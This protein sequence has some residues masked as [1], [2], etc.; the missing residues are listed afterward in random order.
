MSQS[1]DGTT[2]RNESDSNADTCCLG[3]N[4]VILSMTHRTADVYPYDSSYAPMVNVPIVSGAT[5]YDCSITNQTYILVFNEALFYGSK[6][7]HSLI[8]PNQLRSY[9][10][11]FWDNPYDENH[12]LSIDTPCGLFMPLMSKGTKIYFNSRVP[13]RYELENCAHIDMTSKTEWNP[14]SMTLGE[15]RT[16]M[17]E[18]LEYQMQTI[19]TY[20]NPYST[21]HKYHR[22]YMDPTSD[23]AILNNINPSLVQLKELMLSKINVQDS[24]LTDIPARRTFISNKRHLKLSAESIS[25]LWGIGIKRA[26]ATLRAT[27]QRGTRSAI[28][29]LSRRYR[30]D[31][32]YT[33]KR[34]NGKFSTD[35][36][37]A[38]VSSLHHNK[39]A[40]LYSHQ[41]GF[42]VC[43]PM[44]DMSGSTIGHTLKC[45]CHDFGVPELLRS[46]GHQSM[47]G[48]NTLFQELVRLHNIKHTVSE[49]YR[50]SQNPAEPS[51]RDVKM[52]WY[53]IMFKKN[54]PKRVWDYGLIWICETGNISVSSSK[55]AK[56]RTPI[57]TITG[58]TPDITEYTDFSFYDWIVFKPNAGLGTPQ[59]GRW[60]GVSHR[61]GDL[62]SYFVLPISCQ[63]I[64]CVTVQRLTHA[65]QQTEV[66]KEYM[67][68]YNETVST[69]LHPKQELHNDLITDAPKW[70]RLSLED[71]DNDFI[72]SFNRIIDD[73][74]IPHI[75]DF[76]DDGEYTADTTDNYL[77]MELGLPRGVNDTLLHA[78]VKRRAIDINGNPIG[79]RNNNPLLDSRAYEVQF[80]DGSSE[81]IQANIIAENLLSQ[82]DEEGHQQM[83]LHDIIDHQSNSNAITKDK[84]FRTNSYGTKQ[85]VKT[86]KGWK[87][88]VEWK[89]GSFDWVELKDLK[90]AYPVEL[91][92]YAVRHNLQD[93]PVFAWWIPYTLKKR[94]TIISKIKSKYWDRSHKYGFRIPKTVKEAL[95]IDTDEGNNLWREAIE[96]EMKKIIAAFDQYDGD[97]NE[98]IGYQQIT[99]HLIFDIKLG[100]NF[101]RKARLVADGH[102]TQPPA[103]VTYSSV[104]S[105]DSVR[106]CLL[107]AALNDLVILS[108]D[109]ENAY[110]TAPCREKVWTIGGPEFGS[111][112]GQ[113]FIVVKALYGLKSSGAAFRSHLAER[114]DEIG[115][116]SSIADP[117]VWLRPAVKPDG[118]QY[119]EYLLVYVDDLLCI[120][121]DARSP[122]LEISQTLKFKK[123]KIEPPDMYLGGKLK[124]R[125][126]NGRSV[127]TLSCKDYVRAAINIVIK[128]ASARGLKLPA[129]GTPMSSHA[130]PELDAS[131]E[132]NAK[133]ITFYQEMIGMLRWAIELGRVDIHLEVSLLS[134]YQAAPRQGH[135]DELLHIFGFL[136]KHP[137]LTLYFNPDLPMIPPEIFTGDD[138]STFRDHY[139]EAQEELPAHMPPPRGNPVTMTCYVDASH[140]ANKITR[141]S[142][143][144]FIIFLNRAPIIWFSK[145]QNTVESSAFSSEFIAM[146]TCVEEI[147]SMRFK[148]RMLGIPIDGPAKVLCDN[149]SVVNNSSKL[150]SK[151]NK[152]HNSIAYHAVRW[153]RAA[154]IIQVGWIHTSINLADALTKRLTKAVREKLFGDWTY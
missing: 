80:I 115:F 8:N 76:N 132:L 87:I 30:A 62:M 4:F 16:E 111:L 10:V 143:T 27:T 2:G 116:K 44:V 38:E 147:S 52:R 142:H 65:D 66:N 67:T 107:I 49:P 112:E 96:E 92:E 120:S 125:T 109:I 85:R 25:E 35:T 11:H 26:K 121:H 21:I 60:L 90:T 100:E 154:N 75:D 43:Y 14:H 145:R 56:G 69:K 40:Q 32:R 103:S 98:L 31:R 93:E 6:L 78:T 34:L 135:L 99:T 126:L 15:C 70:H 79:T 131:M 137:D 39:F 138:S 94:K 28:L 53:R 54:V 128:G 148:L 150:S 19:E 63:V 58:E 36:I 146:K 141:R 153:A 89:D 105:R 82:V 119:Y 118:Q 144:G 22:S 73:K 122:L 45:F 37:F 33:T 72:D 108:G 51:I 46:D 20:D 110:L 151:L 124:L 9:G 152:K 77:N 86:T 7:D 81:I 104:V 13:T 102:K 50:P 57:E 5:A 71:E 88:C 149:K 95:Q 106:I 84:G 41:V 83:L 42:A 114:L 136:K 140:A 64:S 130:Q 123:N 129:A 117:D 12:Q 59:I 127:W 91:A 47:L 23:E 3:T 139:R 17:R 1:P 18:R 68:K 74:S 29:P 97:P 133:D 101:R 113:A 134:A 61:V 55:Y 48:R 24:E